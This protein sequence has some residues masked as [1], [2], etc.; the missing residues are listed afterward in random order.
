MY[1][2]FD[3]Y[4]IAGQQVSLEPH[5]M[6]DLDSSFP[7]N[8]TLCEAE[9]QNRTTIFHTCLMLLCFL[10]YA[11]WNFYSNSMIVWEKLYI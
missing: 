2:L 5:G 10:M 4:L 1:L 7:F 6:G 3:M 9:K 8:N 11:S